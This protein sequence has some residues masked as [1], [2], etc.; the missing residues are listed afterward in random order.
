MLYV[1]N[2]N[3]YLFIYLFTCIYLF[4]DL[5]IYLFIHLFIYLFFSLTN[6]RYAGWHVGKQQRYPTPVCSGPA[7][8]R[9]PRCDG[10]S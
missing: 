5:F 10:G 7:S 6:A 9:S 3:Y 2:K 4:I 1:V 8:E